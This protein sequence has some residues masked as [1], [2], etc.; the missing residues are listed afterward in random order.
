M[1]APASVPQQNLDA[2]AAVLSAALLSQEAA[3]EAMCA[4]SSG[5]F[6]SDANRRIMGAIEQLCAD[7]AAVDVVAVA[8]LLRAE[9]KLE[10]I[11]GPRY[12]AQI[13]DATPAIAHVAAHAKIV[14]DLGRV[15][16]AC[17]TFKAL[18][19]E[20]YSSIED[21]DAWLEHCEGEVYAATA[22]SLAD[23]D[24][25]GTYRDE[26][27]K[28]LHQ[29]G[30]WSKGPEQRGLR[31]GFRFLDE[32]IGG[33]IA[34]DLWYIGGRPGMG[35]TSLVAQIIEYAAAFDV[36]IVFFSLEMKRDQLVL[37]SLSRRL[38][39]AGFEL[40]IRRLR[41]GRLDQFEWAELT[42]V[43]EELSALPIV[44]DD[45]EGLTPAK[46]R[47]KL[48]RHLATL[49]KRFPAIKLGAVA[50]DYVQLMRPDRARGRN[51][52]R[53]DEVGGISAALKEMAKAFDTPVLALSQLTRPKKGEKV[54]APE[55]QDLRDS[56]ALEADADIVLFVHRDDE[57]RPPSAQRD[58][59]ADLIVA[60]GRNC[61]T[62]SHQV[63][64]DGRYTRFT[65]Q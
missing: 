55:L 58:G 12:L 14:A 62:G 56:G 27:G 63:R 33:L 21:V 54:K 40:P 6:Y 17:A 2:E 18:A 15:R 32:H 41:T 30:E 42:H 59:E 47:A 39:D 38:R 44:I 10:Q 65:D 61:G 34:P 7:G 25:V 31:T 4:V 19:A 53:N 3:D 23:R 36:A 9:G 26:A 8:E 11:G 60:K 37:R 51:E 49:R 35:K 22:N 28:L 43:V 64:F 52:T 48:R 45:A 20:A 5:D 29:I 46:L 16:R 50:I 13:S 57:Y 1:N 24:T